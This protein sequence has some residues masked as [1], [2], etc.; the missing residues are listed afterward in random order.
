[1]SKLPIRTYGKTRKKS[2]EWFSNLPPGMLNLDN[3]GGEPLGLAATEEVQQP[4]W[5]PS[6]DQEH[7]LDRV[8][9]IPLGENDR[10]R[11]AAGT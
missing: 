1:M 10:I 6:E 3:D 8:K 4:A 2:G 9:D 11:I 5:A 7:P